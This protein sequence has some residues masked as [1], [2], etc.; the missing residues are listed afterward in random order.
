MRWILL[1]W[2]CLWGFKRVVRFLKGKE[3]A[4]GVSL[5]ALLDLFVLAGFGYAVNLRVLRRI[6]TKGSCGWT[7]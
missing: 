2:K 6:E 4:L 3:Y 1:F 7:S 5:L